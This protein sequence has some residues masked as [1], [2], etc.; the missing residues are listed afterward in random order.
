MAKAALWLPRRGIQYA[1]YIRQYSKF[2]R[3]ARTTDRPFRLAWTDR[4]PCLDDATSQTGFDRHY[5]YHTAWAAR[6]VQKIRPEFH[7]DIS[8]YLYFS[9]I[10]SA[11]VPVRFYDYRPAKIQLDGLQSEPADLNRLPFESDS[12]ESISCMHVLE[13]IGL[14]RYGDALDVQGDLKALGEL[15]RVVKPGGSL[16]IVLPMGGTDKICFNAHRI[17]TPDTVVAMLGAG[18]KLNQF[19][20][21]EEHGNG[22]VLV[23]P[24]PGVVSQN[25]YGCGCFWFQKTA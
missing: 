24:D 3:E 2:R 1:R 9:T 6:I 17:Y 8:S 11:F 14:G 23:D 4:F 5:I 25:E 21:I 22:G 19:G 7:I 20:F 18:F 13:H 15:K 12:V 16:I 10:V